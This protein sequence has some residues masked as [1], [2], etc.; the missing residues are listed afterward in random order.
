ML[1]SSCGWLGGHRT[2]GTHTLSGG[3]VWREVRMAWVGQTGL[4]RKLRSVVEIQRYLKDETHSQKPSVNLKLAKY[5]TSVLDVFFC[6]SF[7]PYYTAIGCFCLHL[8]NVY[9]H[10][11]IKWLRRILGMCAGSCEYKWRNHIFLQ[12]KYGSQN[13]MGY[14]ETSL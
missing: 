10:K 5:L 8:D 11:S 13:H 2:R 7:C 4:R 14:S 1:Q 12:R 3:V 6:L 9:L